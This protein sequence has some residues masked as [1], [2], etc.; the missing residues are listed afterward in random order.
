[1]VFLMSFQEL[2]EGMHHAPEASAELPAGMESADTAIR[3]LK[4]GTEL[5]QLQGSLVILV[6]QLVG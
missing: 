5:I 4:V 3:R 6:M 1:V 2:R